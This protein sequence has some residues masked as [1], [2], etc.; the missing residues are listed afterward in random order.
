MISI[1]EN[2]KIREAEAKEYRFC[3]NIIE[4]LKKSID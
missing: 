4:Q 1:K 3:I 2:S